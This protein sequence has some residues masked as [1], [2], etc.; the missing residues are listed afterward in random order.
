M[1]ISLLQA[2]ARR[3]SLF[4]TV[5]TRS[6]VEQKGQKSQT[7]FQLKTHNGFQSNG[8]IAPLLR[9]FLQRTYLTPI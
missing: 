8:V 9:N 5:F 4:P 3:G 7:Y 1:D 6:Q 2:T